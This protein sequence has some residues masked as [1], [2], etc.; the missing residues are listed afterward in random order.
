MKKLLIGFSI[1]FVLIVIVSATV[2]LLWDNGIS[3]GE[4]VAIVYIEGP[5][6]TSEDIIDELKEY[7]DDSSVKAIVLR[8]N[9]PG[10]GVAPSQEIFRVVRRIAEQKHVV[11]SMA[12]LAASGGYYIAAPSTSILAN[13]GTLT[14]SIG[15]IMEIPNVESLMDKVGISTEVIKSGEMKDMGSAF[16][17]MSEKDRKVLQEIIYEVYEQFVIDVAE[18]RGMTVDEVREIADGRIL[19][20]SQALKA[21]LVDEMGGLDDA[22]DL[23]ASLAGIDGE[24]DV[25]T[26]KE[27]KGLLSL[28]KGGISGNISTIFPHIK[29]QYMMSP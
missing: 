22:I 28:L 26:K 5:I 24:P 8:V 20:G 25:V 4:K 23:A 29:I 12:S 19:T 15:V 27:D 1:L 10:G 7:E 16:R 2:A 18:S 9:S 14:G 3:I 6:I 11:T 21:G 13:P 17:K